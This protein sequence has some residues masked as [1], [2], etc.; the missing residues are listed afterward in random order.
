[1]KTS[2]LRTWALASTT[3]LAFLAGPAGA[4]RPE[5]SG[6]EV[7][8]TVCASCH[9]TGKLGAPK[10]GDKRAWSARA[11]QGL[12]ALTGHALTGIRNMPA[13]G[14]SP[15]LSDIE[16][17]RAITHMVNRSGGQ[18]IEPL[19]HATPAVLR[20][21]EQI[22]QG[23]CAK[24]HQIGVQGAPRIGDRAAWT[25]RLA[26]GLDKLVKSAVH[27]RGHMPARGGAPEL[28]DVEIQGAILYMFNYGMP[29][30]PP[31]PPQ[32]AAAAPNPYH[33]VL[34][35][36]DVYLGVVRADRLS[37]RSAPGNVPRGK[38]VYH[39]NIS[40]FDGKTGLPITNA[41]VSARVAD[42]TSGETRTLELESANNTVSYGGYFRMTGLNPYSIV[43]QIQR[44]GVATV[45][46]AKFEYRLR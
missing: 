2:S 30:P 22:V 13:H 16:V 33:Q 23:Q 17:E 39:V 46:E 4:Q 24:C 37:E 18:W 36:A 9:A 7:V 27:G 11:S 28:S 35:G 19:G 6:A 41:R 42:A 3:A 34:D 25:P 8:E 31:P 45:S 10:I 26:K 21:S 40:L 12:T 38:D 43:A 32:A 44:P 1:M 15:G 20:T 5:R 29:A 14:G